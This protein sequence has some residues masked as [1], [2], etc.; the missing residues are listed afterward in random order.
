M[1]EPEPRRH[2]VSIVNLDGLPEPRWGWPWANYPPGRV[3]VAAGPSAAQ[4]PPSPPI[5]PGSAWPRGRGSGPTR[6][7]TRTGQSGHCRGGP[8]QTAGGMTSLW[9]Q[10]RRT[11][12]SCFH[13]RMDFCGWRVSIKIWKF[14]QALA[15]K[16]NKLSSSNF[17]AYRVTMQRLDTVVY[18]KI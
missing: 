14:N 1:S 18:E 12:P 10:R 3:Q 16:T 5:G 6:H 8:C 17:T 7:V 11:P 15:E 4:R 9:S 2:A 13:K